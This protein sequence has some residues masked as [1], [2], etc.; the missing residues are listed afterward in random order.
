MAMDSNDPFQRDG[1]SWGAHLQ[2]SWDLF[3]GLGREGR[4]QQATAAHRQAEAM[5][6]LRRQQAAV[7]VRRAFLH[8]QSADGRIDVAEQ[9]VARAEESLRIVELQYREG[10]TTVS[11]LLD[12][13][14]AL[15]AARGRHIQALHDLNVQMAALELAAGDPV[16]PDVAK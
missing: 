11:T 14:A 10:L 4:A 15:T 13:E 9:A 6:R 5:A 8:V 3:S 16:V 2:M 12:N 7:E 1:E